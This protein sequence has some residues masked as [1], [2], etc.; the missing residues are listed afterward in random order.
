MEKKSFLAHIRFVRN[1]QD[2]SRTTADGKLPR[3][4]EAVSVYQVLAP[5]SY[6]NYSYEDLHS[7]ALGHN[8]LCISIVAC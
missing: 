5:P 2:I 4:K 1:L 8:D 6:Q 3:L 7:S